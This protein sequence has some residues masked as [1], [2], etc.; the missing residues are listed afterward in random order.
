MT[1]TG[2][3][4]APPRPGG[5]AGD[6]RHN[7]TVHTIDAGFFGLALGVASFV[8][9][10]PLFLATFTDSPLA[11]G[12]I[13]SI[14]PL[15]WHLPQLLTADRVN[16]LRRYMP[17]ILRATTMER[18]PFFLLAGLAWASPRLPAAATVLLT[19]ALVLWIG[20]G[21]GLTSTPFQ[22]LVAKIIPRSRQGAFYGLKT[23]AANLMLAIGAV[24]AGAILGRW[25]GGAGFALC[26][27]L[28]G[29]ATGVSWAFLAWTRE[30]DAEP[31]VRLASGQA[32]E[33][34]RARAGR[35]LAS[36]V[37]FRWFLVARTAAQTTVMASAYYTVYAIQRFGAGPAT[38][39]YL[40]AAFAL[41]QTVGNPLMGW[42]GDHWGHRRTMALGM[43]AGAA[44]AGVALAAPSA[45]WLFAAFVLTGIANVAAFTL[46][47]ALNLR[48]GAPDQRTAYIGLSSSLTAPSIVLAPMV[49]GWL[50]GAAGF[51]AAFAVAAA[52]GLV[53]AAVLL[54]RVREPRHEVALRDVGVGGG[55]A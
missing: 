20:I 5:G 11:I 50:A 25:P 2:P 4:P 45:S 18:V 15:G 26:F 14:Q 55:V 13:A 41:A 16:R 28:A 53:A 8:S 32:P 23:G 39:G 9:V 48:F 40:T 36:D 7:F 35:I 3:G 19:Y 42:L 1:T 52:G 10:L 44:G 46:P 38:A 30:A 31:V 54:A 29:L 37:N 12:L 51:R 34:L 27:V 49:G 21:G 33:R 22:A 17:M 24:A 6:M 47:L 43:L